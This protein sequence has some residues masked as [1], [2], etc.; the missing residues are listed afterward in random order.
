MITLC[1]ATERHHDRRGNEEVWHTFS[2]GAE[3]GSRSD[4]FA[5]LAVL[6]ESSLS[7]GGDIVRQPERELEIVTY[8]REGA[9]AQEDSTGRS[10]VVQAGEFQR[11]AAAPGVRGRERNASLAD[12]A[13]VF[14]LGLGPLP[15]GLEASHE[16]R[17]FSTA[18]RRGGLCVVA[19]PDGRSSS[20]RLAQ[21]VLMF[22]AILD[23]G[24]H[25]V[26]ELSPERGAWLHVVQG[27]VTLDGLVLSS[28]DGAGFTAERS[29]S[30]TAREET[31]ILLVDLGEQ[32][33][34]ARRAGGVP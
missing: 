10:G 23:P 2:R 16:Q 21:D 12:Y 20:L 5:G 30:L 9:L 18:Q 28:G 17:R 6:D 13:R 25:V 34:A 15:P 32:P 11:L 7:P 8:V 33:A 3:A 14:Q 24:Q 29:V 22:S 1:R 31:E 27:E 19:S 26:H 4:G